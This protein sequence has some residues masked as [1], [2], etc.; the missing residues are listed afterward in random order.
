MSRVE[1]LLAASPALTHDD[2][3]EAFWQACHGGQRRAAERLLR[4]G[5]DIDATPGYAQQTALQIAA[6]SDTRREALITWLRLSE[7]AS[8]T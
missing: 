3:N 1:E 5:A 4:H 6:G 2:I 8:G 7:L